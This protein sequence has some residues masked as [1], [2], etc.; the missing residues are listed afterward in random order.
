MSIFTATLSAK[1]FALLRNAADAIFSN[2]T[3][4]ESWKLISAWDEGS[5]AFR[6]WDW[7]PLWHRAQALDLAHRINAPL[8]WWDRGLR[9]PSSRRRIVQ[10]AAMCGAV[11]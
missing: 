8:P 1:D 3:C 7:N 6:V 2:Y 4:Y 11:R 9:L 5:F 10:R